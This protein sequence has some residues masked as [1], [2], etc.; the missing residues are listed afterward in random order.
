MEIV[1]ASN[2]IHIHSPKKKKKKNITPMV[3]FL[4]HLVAS[5]Y[6]NSNHLFFFYVPLHVIVL[7]YVSLLVIVLKM[8]HIQEKKK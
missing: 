6:L 5:I 8:N 3:K 7:F 4:V 1:I 2:I